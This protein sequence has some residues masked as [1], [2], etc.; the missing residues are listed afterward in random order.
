MSTPTGPPRPQQLP[1]AQQQQPAQPLDSRTPQYV[2]APA[3]WA[4][5]SETRFGVLPQEIWLQI[6]E[7]ALLRDGDLSPAHPG[8][9]DTVI[10]EDEDG[11]AV[12]MTLVWILGRVSQSIRN[13][14]FNTFFS[15]NRFLLETYD[16]Y[17]VHVSNEWL[18]SI[19]DAAIEYLGNVA[20]I[21][22]FN[23]GKSSRRL[24]S[25]QNLIRTLGRSRFLRQLHLSVDTSRLT[26]SKRAN[27]PSEMVFKLLGQFRN[28]L[29]LTIAIDRDWPEAEQ[30]LRQHMTAPRMTGLRGGNYMPASLQHLPGPSLAHQWTDRDY[31]NWA[32][33]LGIDRRVD[34]ISNRDIVQMA[35]DFKNDDK[36]A[37][38]QLSVGQRVLVLPRRPATAPRPARPS[39]NEES[40]LSTL[41]I[42]WIRNRQIR[43]PGTNHEGPDSLFGHTSTSGQKRRLTDNGGSDC[44][45]PRLEDAED[46]SME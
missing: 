1:H 3:T 6:L 14:A 4:K 40:A 25:T 39:T 33:A 20:V 7:L 22:D 34:P 31:S 17:E 27:F 10:L 29:R 19:P 11:A 23:A 38:A 35:K 46:E 8:L 12:D 44:K 41:A 13:L 24:R 42:E 18:G 2:P 32:L 36:A 43:R 30:W 21:I 16:G 26:H 37:T 15:K 5:G 9:T 28:I 45:R